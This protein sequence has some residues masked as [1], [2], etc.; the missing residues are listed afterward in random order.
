MARYP[1]LAEYRAQ[2]VMA[3]PLLVSGEVIGAVAFLHD[4]PDAR[5]D[6][7]AAAKAT[8][9][10]AQLGTALEAVRLSL[11]S[12]EER[13]RAMI[14][15]EI[16][17]ALHGLPDTSAVMEGIADRLRVLLNSPAVLV[18]VHEADS[19]RLQAVS[20]DPPGLAQSIRAREQEDNLRSA[21]D[22][23]ARAVAAGERITV[24]IDGASHLERRRRLEFSLLPHF[25]LRART[26]SSWSTRAQLLNLRKKR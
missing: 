17:T 8:I 12:K 24:S 1:R 15:A 3:A 4:A 23:A 20:A 2:S 22:I 13:R 11:V 7:D 5:F 16:A 25:A 9:L 14:L 6:E 18:F 10:A 21:L 19:F 26:E